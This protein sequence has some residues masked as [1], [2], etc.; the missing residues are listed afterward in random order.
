MINHPNVNI[1]ATIAT[2]FNPLN[3]GTLVISKPN[4]ATPITPPIC[5]AQE[6][7]ADAELA[8]SREA[9]EK[10][11]LAMPGIAKEVQPPNNIIGKNS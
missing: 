8:S 5:L 7:N 1:I 9:C 4:T 2:N 11:R 3:N 6:N 10:I